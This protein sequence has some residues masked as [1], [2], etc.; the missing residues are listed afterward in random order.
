MMAALLSFS[1]QHSHYVPGCH[2]VVPTSGGQLRSPWPGSLF[3]S[4]D[5]YELVASRLYSDCC[6]L[7]PHDHF[8]LTDL[9]NVNTTQFSTYPQSPAVRKRSVC[10]LSTPMTD[11]AAQG[12]SMCTLGQL[13]VIVYNGQVLLTMKRHQK[14]GP[15]R[16]FYHSNSSV[17]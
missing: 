1:F 13:V 16:T 7:M 6:R 2:M 10:S 15:T 9:S 8:V 14:A 17:P 12:I 3:R 5:Q 4:D 11:S